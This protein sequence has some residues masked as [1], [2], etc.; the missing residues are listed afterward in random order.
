MIE[1]EWTVAKDLWT[2][3]S[4][5]TKPPTLTSLLI[6]V[7]RCLQTKQ[8]TVKRAH[9]RL[10]KRSTRLLHG[11]AKERR[12]SRNEMEMRFA[13]N[14]VFH[15]LPDCV[16]AN[17]SIHSTW[18][19]D[20]HNK[21]VVLL[22]TTTIQSQFSVLTKKFSTSPFSGSIWITSKPQV[23]SLYYWEW[24]ILQPLSRKMIHSTPVLYRPFF[25]Y[26]SSLSIYQL[27]SVAA[28]LTS[29]EY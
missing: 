8:K 2:N 5:F 21:H 18:R 6:E 22:F 25:H 14:R 4:I 23:L 1:H 28:R 20:R 11:I 16:I 13:M 24:S 15:C 9:H 12:E 10:Q 3:N 19:K 29:L 17:R 26:R 27:I 7:K